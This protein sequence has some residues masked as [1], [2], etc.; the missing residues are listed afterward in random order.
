VNNIRAWH[1]VWHSPDEILFKLPFELIIE[2]KFC[3]LAQVVGILAFQ[4]TL[5][6]V[7]RGGQLLSLLQTLCLLR[8]HGRS[9]VLLKC[10]ACLLDHARD[11]GAM[12]ILLRL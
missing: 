5:E 10:L 1:P 2:I 12:A 9:L 6:V 3:A 4:L 7:H 11:I 8:V